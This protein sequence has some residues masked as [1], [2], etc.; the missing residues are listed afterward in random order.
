M[1]RCQGTPWSEELDGKE[2]HGA[3][4]D[5]LDPRESTV[6]CTSSTQ[7]Q[8]YPFTSICECGIVLFLGGGASYVF[9]LL[10]DCLFPCEL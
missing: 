9:F 7:K 6:S 10:P 5:G 4:G 2:L 1:N 8:N 3:A